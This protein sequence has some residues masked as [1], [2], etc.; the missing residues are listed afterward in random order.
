VR[1]VEIKSHTL[2][3][4][5]RDS[6]LVVVDDITDRNNAE[7][8]RLKLEAQLRQSQKMEAVGQLA[9]GIAHDF[10]N[11]LSVVIN[12]ASF[13]REEMDPSA[14][15]YRD[16]SEIVDAGERGANLVRQILAFSRGEVVD[17][18]IVNLNGAVKSM[19]EM[20][21]RT[22]GE[23]IELELRL[24]DDLR[25]VSIDRTQVE[26]VLLNLAVN[27]RDAMKQG[28]RLAI[29]TSNEEFDDLVAEQ[30]PE[31]AP[32]HYVSISVSDTGTGMDDVVRRRIFEPFYT[33]KT[34]GEGTGL[35]LAMVYGVIQRASGHIYVYSEPG[36][37]T[38]FRIYLPVAEETDS[39]LV[40]QKD[41]P[42]ADLSGTETVL[43]VED[44]P[45]VRSLTARILERS[46]YTVVAAGSG[47]EAAE[48][49]RNRDG[50]FDVLLTDVIMP[51]MSGKEL[52][53]LLRA[54]DA[55]LRVLFMSGYTDA[56]VASRGMLQ[57]S[58]A[59]VQKPFAASTLLRKVREVLDHSMSSAG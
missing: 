57:E 4:E 39:A 15:A 18:E 41:A 45:A 14:E 36:I 31:L 49:W 26:Q 7:R 6:V 40:S 3:F 30:H 5:G 20:L 38:R 54:Q 35:G 42:E 27:A 32:G 16:V 33:T 46:G 52:S 9:G 13:L 58:E 24:A 48:A 51:G 1:E 21:Q 37:G 2:D 10:N 43:L 44:E 8:Q 22:L 12:Y 50:A 28:G 55:D 59:L 34:V 53:E 56:I 17:P 19:K 25:S 11:I 23:D 29:E 47:K